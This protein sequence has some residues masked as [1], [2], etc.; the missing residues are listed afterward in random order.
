[1]AYIY[2]IKKMLSLTSIF[3]EQAPAPAQVT[4]TATVVPKEVTAA[5][6]PSRKKRVDR[7]VFSDFRI[8]DRASRT[9][10]TKREMIEKLNSLYSKEDPATIEIILEIFLNGSD[11]LK[12][13]NDVYL[14]MAND[15]ARLFYIKLHKKPLQGG[16]AEYSGPQTIPTK[17]KR[18]EFTKFEKPT[19]STY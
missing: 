12:R 6:V 17:M 4:K 15:I 13:I 9:V 19:Y 2:K 14:K 8:I 11:E 5:N 7:F 16:Y 18:D 1:M 3:S 10:V